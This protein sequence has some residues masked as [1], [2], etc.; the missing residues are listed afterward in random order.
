M[1]IV[2]VCVLSGLITFGSSFSDRTRL[3]GLVH[4]LRPNLPLYL[5]M[6]IFMYIIYTCVYVYLS[7]S[8][9]I[10]SCMHVYIY[11][12]MY[13]RRYI[14]IHLHIDVFVLCMCMKVIQIQKTK[15][16]MNKVGIPKSEPCVQV[17]TFF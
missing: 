13:V 14:Y 17:A 11:I 9:A 5:K 4:D 15:T 6:C 8:L 2:F 10:V 7:L 1:Y 3:A 16:P 12:Y